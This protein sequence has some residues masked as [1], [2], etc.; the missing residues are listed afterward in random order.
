MV[1]TKNDLSTHKGSWDTGRGLFPPQGAEGKDAAAEPHKPGRALAWALP[2]LRQVAGLSPSVLLSMLLQPHLPPRF[3]FL[4][5]TVLSLLNLCNCC[6]LGLEHRSFTPLPT[7]DASSPA[8]ILSG[9]PSLV[10]GSHLP[11]PSQKGMDSKCL[12]NSLCPPTPAQGM[13][14][15]P[16]TRLEAPS[17]Q[18]LWSHFHSCISQMEPQRVDAS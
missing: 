18:G 14:L 13:S 7:L 9:G 6:S 10:L 17:Q 16:P 5:Y 15:R 4:E 2:L 8:P 12:G 11:S 1:T 3:Q